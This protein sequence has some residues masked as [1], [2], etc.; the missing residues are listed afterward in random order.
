M[1]N[2]EVIEA[3]PHC[4]HHGLKETVHPETGATAMRR[5]VHPVEIPDQLQDEE[6][7]WW[8]DAPDPADV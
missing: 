5:C 1:Y 2:R 6:P 7:N 8:D 3:C 4:D